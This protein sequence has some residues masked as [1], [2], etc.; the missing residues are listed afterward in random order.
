LGVLYT[1]IGEVIGGSVS[2][3]IARRFGRPIVVRLVGQ[4][5][6]R[7]V[8]S[9]YENQLGGWYSLAVARLVLFSV[10]DFLSYAAGLAK[11]VSFRAYFLV[12]VILGF[13]PTLFF[14]WIGNT[15]VEDTSALI[16]VYVLVGGLIVLPVI[17]RKQVM[18]LLQRNAP[19]A[20]PEIGD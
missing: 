20:Q 12:S 2:F 11:T 5:N 4:K 7:Q 10:W 18:R 19:S 3:W 6:M 17:F 9:F 15:A 16:W 13:I 8:D 14:V 1:L